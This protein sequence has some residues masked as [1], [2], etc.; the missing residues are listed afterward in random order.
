M[1]EVRFRQMPGHGKVQ[2]KEYALESDRTN[3]DIDNAL[4]FRRW[5]LPG[6]EVDMSMVFDDF[7]RRTTS[8]PGCGMIATEPTDSKLKWSVSFHSKCTDPADIQ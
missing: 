3:Q 5:F 8:C 6:Q 1:L 7:V 2:R 4:A